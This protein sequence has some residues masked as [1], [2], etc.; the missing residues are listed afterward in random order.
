[1]LRR[2]LPRAQGL[3][4]PA[5]AR[6]RRYSRQLEVRL[7]R[8]D[9]RVDPKRDP[10]LVNCLVEPA[11]GGEDDAEVVVGVGKKRRQPDRFTELDRGL[12]ELPLC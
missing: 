1:M 7:R 12:L 8:R 6:S 2:L 9:G 3:F 11:E 10:K 4:A 5:A